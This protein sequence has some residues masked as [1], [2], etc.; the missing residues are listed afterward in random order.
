MPTVKEDVMFGLLNYG[1]SSAEAEEKTDSI[2]S[3]L[4][5][6]N[7][8]ERHNHRLS[9]GEKRM[10]AIAAV[11]AMDHTHLLMDEPCSA[12]DPRNRRRIINTLKSLDRAMLIASH[13]L[14]MILDTCS[15]TVIL[16][17]GKIIADGPTSLLLTDKTLLEENNL[18]LPLRY[19]LSQEQQ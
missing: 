6:L 1:M 10:A 15:R 4:G 18:E 19:T 5:I 9:G 11:L 2:L 16:S 8:K 17:D 13:D 14:D 7:L 12:L 3:E